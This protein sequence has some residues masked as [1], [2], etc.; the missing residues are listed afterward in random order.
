[1]DGFDIG[2]VGG[3]VD[4]GGIS[5]KQSLINRTTLLGENIMSSSSLSHGGEIKGIDSSSALPSFL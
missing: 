3:G 2:E 5:G 4:G 1:M